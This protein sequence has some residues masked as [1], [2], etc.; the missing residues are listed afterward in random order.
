MSKQMRSLEQIK[1]NAKKVTEERMRKA[2]NTAME[3]DDDYGQLVAK[4]KLTKIGKDFM[5]V[6]EEVKEVKK[7]SKKESK[8]ES[9]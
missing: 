5:G 6:K 3:E 1:A 4:G 7:V 2:I 8:K 9:K